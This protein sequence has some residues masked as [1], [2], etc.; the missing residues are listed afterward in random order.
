MYRK[1][2]ILDADTDGAT[3]LAQVAAECRSA[4][5]SVQETAIVLSDVQD[6]LQGMIQSGRA[7]A[8]A[9][10]QYQADREIG[11]EAAVITLM[12]RYGMRP[13]LLTRLWSALR[14]RS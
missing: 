5:L 14:R 3:V 4:G 1:Q 9:G 13:G 6:P 11:T 10:G 12:A 8:A 7:V 2:V